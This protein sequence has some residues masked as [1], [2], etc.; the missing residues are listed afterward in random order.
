MDKAVKGKKLKYPTFYLDWFRARKLIPLPAHVNA[1]Q[2]LILNEAGEPMPFVHISCAAIGLRR[3]ATKHGRFTL[4]Y[5]DE[6]I[7]TI[8]YE[9]PGYETV[10]Q[11]VTFYTGLRA[12][13]LVTMRLHVVP[14]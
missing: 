9:F 1:A 4:R 12:D 6:G 13:I 3:K 7:Q 8:T 10:H 11:Q 2:G 5:A 14:A